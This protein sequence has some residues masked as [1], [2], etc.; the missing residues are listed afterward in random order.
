[1]EHCI[2]V[3]L[4]CPICIFIICAVV[5]CFMSRYAFMTILIGGILGYARY[6]SH[7]CYK[8]GTHCPGIFNFW[9]FVIIYNTSRIFRS[10][11]KTANFAPK[12][13]TDLAAQWE[14][15]GTLCKRKYSLLTLLWNFDSKNTQKLPLSVDSPYDRSYHH[16]LELSFQNPKFTHSYFDLNR[17]FQ[18]R[19]KESSKRTNDTRKKR[20]EHKV[21]LKNC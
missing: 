4:A 14:L 3:D 16:A 2:Q 13:Y 15:T 19:R 10:G 9:Y 1:M 6:I 21:R 17:S 20:K 8:L 12:G 5:N 11:S 7:H 18:S